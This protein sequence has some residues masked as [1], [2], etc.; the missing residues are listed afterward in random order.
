MTQEPTRRDMLKTV[1]RGTGLV[2]LGGAGTYL[3]A[4]ADAD[5]TW[6]V[7]PTNE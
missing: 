3:V 5:G 1:A 4:R 6:R 2:V 7:D